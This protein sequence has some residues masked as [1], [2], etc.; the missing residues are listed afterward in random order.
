MELVIDEMIATRGNYY[1]QK[2]SKY[3]PRQA[4][5]MT[6]GTSNTGQLRQFQYLRG[7]V[8]DNRLGTNVYPW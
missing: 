4:N 3:F 6:Y 8:I 5:A 2:I 7:I 1:R